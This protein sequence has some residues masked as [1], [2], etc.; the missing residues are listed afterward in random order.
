[1]TRTDAGRTEGIRSARLFSLPWLVGLVGFSLF[2][3]VLSLVLSFVQWKGLSLSEDVNWI[4]WA[5]YRRIF[6]FDRQ[7]VLAIRNNL[8]YSLMAVPCGVGFSLAVALLLN[9]RVRGVALF[10]SLFMLPYMLGGVA[11]AMVWGWL[12]NPRYGWVN[13]VMETVVN[14]RGPEWFYSPQ[15]C[16]PALAIMY[17]WLGGGSMMVALAAL[18]GVREPLLDAATIDGA[19][20]WRRLRHVTLPHIAPALFF[21]LIVGLVYAMQSFDLPYLLQNRAQNDELLM[22]MTYL[23]RLAFEPPYDFSYGCAASWVFFVAMAVLVAPILLLARR[24]T[25]YEAGRRPIG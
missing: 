12:L 14:W 16:K 13:E 4:G 8:V 18:Q 7:F 5:N 6:G 10:R 22:Y 11:T 21:N 9:S 3:A 1:M 23:Y 25:V 20:A 2:P 15:W 19:D 24:L 17:C